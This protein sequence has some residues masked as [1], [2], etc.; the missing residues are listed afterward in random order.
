M[1]NRQPPMAKALCSCLF[2]DG[3]CVGAP[4]R[5]TNH[6]DAR[7]DGACLAWNYRK[8]LHHELGAPLP[9]VW[10]ERAKLLEGRAAE[11]HFGYCVLCVLCLCVVCTFKLPLATLTCKKVKTD[12]GFGLQNGWYVLQYIRRTITTSTITYED[13]HH[14]Q[15]LRMLDISSHVSSCIDMERYECE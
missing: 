1:I 7:P 15:G 11:A 10:R 6:G 2:F 9:C 3:A 12:W 4:N 5:Q 14:P 13:V 8:R